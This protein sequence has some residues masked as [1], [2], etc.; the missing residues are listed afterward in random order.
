M[1][2]CVICYTDLTSE[3][4]KSVLGCGHEFHIK[5][6]GQWLLSGSASCPYCRKEAGDMERIVKLSDS[7]SDTYDSEDD[8][9]SNVTP[10][11]CA[12]RRGDLTIVLEILGQDKSAHSQEDSDG[13]TALFYAA[14]IGRTEVA[15]ALIQAGACVNHQN[16]LGLTPIMYSG[17]Q[18]MTETLLGLGADANHASQA[19]ETA[20]VKAAEDNKTDILQV[21]LEHGVGHMDVALHGACAAGSYESAQLLLEAGVDPNC[22]VVEGGTP[23]MRAV[24]AGYSNAEM[25]RLLLSKGADVRATDDNGWNAFMWFAD[26]GSSDTETMMLLLDAAGIID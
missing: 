16:H 25:V 21:L 2:E 4:G 17:F 11:M 19:N 12:A 14:N 5:C 8:S 13:D 23:L 26:V 9:V 1:T 3:T 22:R 24:C 20:L 7:D 6:V 10:L 18:D 15:K